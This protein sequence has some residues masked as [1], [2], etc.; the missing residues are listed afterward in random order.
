MNRDEVR[1]EIRGTSRSEKL[2]FTIERFS[3]FCCFEF[4]GR[5]SGPLPHVACLCG[6]TVL[7]FVLLSY[8][9]SLNTI[10]SSFSSLGG[11]LAHTHACRYGT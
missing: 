1:P 6:L 4:G 5:K 11:S 3:Q 2:F 8:P 7:P 9:F 10:A